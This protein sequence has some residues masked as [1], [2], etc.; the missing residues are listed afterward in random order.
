MPHERIGLDH[1]NEVPRRRCKPQRFLDNYRSEEPRITKQPAIKKRIMGHLKH[2]LAEN[3]S[4][5]I[6]PSNSD[7]NTTENRTCLTHGLPINF[8]IRNL[9]NQIT[10]GLVTPRFYTSSK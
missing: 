6:T 7:K 10:T 3:L 5:R 1:T 4:S 9:Q 8:Y 2:G